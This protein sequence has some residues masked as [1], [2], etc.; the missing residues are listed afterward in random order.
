M[1]Q[2]TIVIPVKNEQDKLLRC[3]HSIQSSVR[4]S[5][6]FVIVDDQSTDATYSNAVQALNSGQFTGQIILNDGSQGIGAGA[7]RNIGLQHVPPDSDY[8]LFFDADDVMPT[9]VLDSWVFAMEQSKADVS[10][11]QY[12]YYISDSTSIGM[13]KSDRALWQKLLLNP[14]SISESS[15]RSFLL[16]MINYPWNKL[17]R[18]EFAKKINLRFS[19]TPVHNDIFAH[20]QILLNAQQIHLFSESVCRHFVIS[21]N[22]QITNIFDQKRLALIPVLEEVQAYFYQTKAENFHFYP[23][24]LSFKK[25]VLL[26]AYERIQ[27]DLKPHFSQ[28]VQ[29]SYQ[30]ITSQIVLEASLQ[31]PGASLQAGL[32]KLGMDYDPINYRYNI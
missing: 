15:H 26:W 25:S 12:E 17:L 3:I 30:D 31:D 27:P 24:F 5:C 6:H 18:Y 20:W 4:T 32:M 7:C 10:V 16:K 8:L 19:S 29:E 11:A 23:T 21:G 14:D 13:N 22:E 1:S 28:L 2:L 9:E